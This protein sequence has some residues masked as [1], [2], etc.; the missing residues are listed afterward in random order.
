[1]SIA[2]STSH[3]EDE[4]VQ[5]V[6]ATNG[7]ANDGWLLREITKRPGRGLNNLDVDTLTRLLR[8][9]E[10]IRANSTLLLRITTGRTGTQPIS[11]R[12]GTV[13]PPNRQRKT[14]RSK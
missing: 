12:D 8:E 11:L 3:I 14:A 6:V 4:A 9:G 13:R 2:I 5:S 7:R 10:R 1:M